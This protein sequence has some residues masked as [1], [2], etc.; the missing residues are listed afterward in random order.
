MIATVLSTLAWIVGGAAALVVAFGLLILP[1]NLRVR[2]VRR[3]Y[4]ALPENVK[5]RVLELIARY[6]EGKPSVTLLRLDPAAPYDPAK[7]AAD[8]HVGGSPYS[9]AGQPWPLD[10]DEQPA[11]FLIQVRLD[12]PSLGPAWQGRLVQVFFQES[13]HLIVRSYAA[14][15]AARHVAPATSGPVSPGKAILPLRYPAERPDK[16]EGEDAELLPISEKLL[17]LR[18]PEIAQALQ[19]YTN[20]AAGV[21]AQILAPGI[22]GYSC[23]GCVSYVGGTPTLIQNPHD[24]Q[25]PTCQKA[26]RFLFF[27]GE[28]VDEV[29]LGDA[30]TCCVYGCDQHPDQIV[31]M[32]DSY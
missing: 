4:A 13:D 20:D 7:L 25:C 22:Y 3:I 21:T 10:E 27:F 32:V 31:T 9:E 17:V 11:H 5:Q 1:H 24:A 26:M 30:G 23:E 28:L 8:S 29:T 14:P 18:I 6:A 15:S 19:P 2:R 12:E 16:D